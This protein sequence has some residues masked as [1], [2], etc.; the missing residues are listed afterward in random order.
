LH[1]ANFADSISNINRN[2]A[3]I[4]AVESINWQHFAPQ[5]HLS[6]SLK[7]S[8]IPLAIASNRNRSG[9]AWFLLVDNYSILE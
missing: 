1:N 4:I 8:V 3:A 2:S 9:L 6:Q 5:P 7:D